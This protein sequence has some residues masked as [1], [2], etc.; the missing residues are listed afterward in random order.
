[1]IDSMEAGMRYVIFKE[2]SL[3][4]LEPVIMPGISR[5]L[6]WIGRVEPLD[7]RPGLSGW[8]VLTWSYRQMD[9][10]VGEWHAESS[11]LRRLV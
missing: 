9:A 6:E 10:L 7:G 1:M 5:G 2:A 3:T 11:T 4:E 8:L